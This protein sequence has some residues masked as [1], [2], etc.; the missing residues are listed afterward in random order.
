MT[1]EYLTDSH[2]L[3]LP[4]SL[5]PGAYQ[6][7]IGFYFSDGARLPVIGVEGQMVDDRLVLTKPLVV[8]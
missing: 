4:A 8:N 6:I 7:E 2:V 3:R 1:G 5:P